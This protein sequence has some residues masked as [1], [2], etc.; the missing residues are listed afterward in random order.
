MY[1]LYYLNRNLQLGTLKSPTMDQDILIPE[2]LIF[3]DLRKDTHFIKEP[4]ECIAF[5]DIERLI[6]QSEF[7]DMELIKIAEFRKQNTYLSP[8]CQIDPFPDFVQQGTMNYYTSEGEIRLI[9][10]F[11]Y[12]MLG[13]YKIYFSNDGITYQI[14]DPYYPA[15]NP[16]ETGESEAI[17]QPFVFPIPPSQAWSYIYFLD[18]TTGIRS[19]V[20]TDIEII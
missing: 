20:Y 1:T 15:Q 13:R 10:K 19:K 17:V 16:K 8:L 14:H 3:C 11:S 9:F 7:T 18:L 6:I 12:Q 2:E 5:T 4:H